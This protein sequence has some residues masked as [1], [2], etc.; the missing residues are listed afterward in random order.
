MGKKIGIA[1]A[2]IVG[3]IIIGMIALRFIINPENYRG[4]IISQAEK[5]LN[6]REVEIGKIELKLLGFGVKINQLVVSN[7]EGFSDEPLID[8]DEVEVR[9]G[10]FSLL[11]DTIKVKKIALI[12]PLIYVERND[13][14]VTSLDDFL[15][16]SKE[17]KD[18]DAGA[19]VESET[20]GEGRNFL[21]KSVRIKGGELT[22][23]DMDSPTGEY[24]SVQIKQLDVVAKDLALD[25]PV[26]LNLSAAICSETQ[27]KNFQLKGTVGPIG[28]AFEFKETGAELSLEFHPFDISFL[29]P[30]YEGSLPVE[31]ASGIL[32]IDLKVSGRADEGL[33]TSGRVGIREFAY[34]DKDHTWMPTPKFD[35]MFEHS[36]LAR[37]DDK[38]FSLD[39]GT[40][41]V[42]GLT[43]NIT[44]TGEVTDAGLKFSAEATSNNFQ[45]EPLIAILG[46][47]KKSLQDMGVELKGSSALSLHASSDAKIMSAALD[48]NLGN[49]KLT[50]P[51][52]LRKVPGEECHVKVKLRISDKGYEFEQALARLTGFELSVSGNIGTGK[53]MPADLDFRTN[54]VPLNTFKSNL[55]ILKDYNLDG[56]LEL[57][58]R[59]SG[60]LEDTD[61]LT[62][63]LGKASFV[64]RH[65]DLDFN[66]SITGFSS[67]VLDFELSSR[68]IDLDKILA[69]LPESEPAE[70]K[71][72]EKVAPSEAL[73]EESF[74][75]KASGKATINIKKVIYEKEPIKNIKATIKIKKGRF[76]SRDLGLSVAGGTFSMPLTLDFRGKHLGYSVEPKFRNIKMNPLLTAFTS[77]DNSIYGTGKGAM[78]IQGR[79]TEWDVASKSLKGSGSIQI[80]DGTIKNVDLVGG[81]LGDWINSESLE[82]LSRL[83][84]GDKAFERNIE[85][86][87]KELSA[88][89]G[90]GKG[91]ITVKD[92]KLKHDQGVFKLE[93]KLGLDYK[94]NLRGRVIF[95]KDAS[96]DFAKQA[97]IPAD[98]PGLF[99]CKGRLVLALRAKG[100]YPDD[101]RI[102]LDNKKYGEI[103]QENLKC[104]LGEKIEETIMK[105]GEKL[106]KDLFN[107]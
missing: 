25:R 104:G 40:L 80:K 97:G 67:P 96:R 20:K 51:D 22:F 39:K 31:V 76:I 86:R 68:Q 3:V 59:I 47:V 29:R 24:V 36:G 26:S 62:I 54:T 78:K 5:A 12:Q 33:K 102:S 27:E 83:A 103:I 73:D 60:S 92:C 105:E 71:G 30:Y 69:D 37:L 21:V 95:N 75:A 43:L 88:E 17:E 89:F 99:D 38:S 63:T 14:G 23:D 81:V 72:V 93:G 41:Q 98:L 65:S 85:T 57:A 46:P 42:R 55:V 70:T 18:P 9:V 77:L 53:G 87:F 6:G 35:L 91:K 94:A 1:A 34:V 58:G 2:V 4:Q 64:A 50:Y 106:L 66:G 19:P 7:L 48:L 13:K 84:L 82:K 8:V 32:D 28:E 49:A 90:V 74:L 56:D 15:K 79:G 10:L 45:L 16:P 101:L 44:G 107:P 52:I 61:R 100:R 11:T